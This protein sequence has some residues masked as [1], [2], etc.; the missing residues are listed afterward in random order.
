M[1][2]RTL[3]SL[4]ATVAFAVH[5]TDAAETANSARHVARTSMKICLQLEG[6]NLPAT[7]NDRPAARDFAALLPLTLTLKDYAATEK[8]SDL[9]RRLSTSAAPAGMDPSIGDIAF[10][11]PWGNL[12]IFYRDAGYAAGLIKLGQLDGGAAELSRAGP[13]QVTIAA[14]D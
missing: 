13:L 12:A 11:A 14:C 4:V 7:L 9:P 8:I 6:K 5:G 10:Y 2:S 1:K 3:A